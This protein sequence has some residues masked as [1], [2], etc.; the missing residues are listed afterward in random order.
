MGFSR[1]E[2]WSGVLF[3]SPGDLPDPGIEPGSPAS[4]TDAL[5]SEPPGKPVLHMVVSKCQ[6]YSLN[7]YHPLLPPVCSQVHSLC[8]HLQSCPANR[9]IMTILLLS[10]RT[11]LPNDIPLEGR[12]RKSSSKAEILGVGCISF[13]PQGPLL[14]R[15][16]EHLCRNLLLLETPHQ[17]MADPSLNAGSQS[18]P[19]LTREEPQGMRISSQSRKPT[20]FSRAGFALVVS[21]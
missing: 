11:F 10:N 4:Q 6:C 18:Q 2:Y 7:L 19:G 5:P 17:C 9:F 13:A 12:I 3:P 8:L 20:W 14:H 16:P 21:F 15:T 1:Q